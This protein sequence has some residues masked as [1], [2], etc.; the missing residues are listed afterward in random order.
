MENTPE[1]KDSPLNSKYTK[2]GKSVQID[3]YENSQNGWLL[4]IVDEFDNSTC[5]EDPF[6]TDKEAFAEAT[7]A[8]EEEGIDTFIGIPTK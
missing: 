3:I 4:E 2:D 6:P 8:I 7:K 1:F 5:W